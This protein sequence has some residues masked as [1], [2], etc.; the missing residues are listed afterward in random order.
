MFRSLR[1]PLSVAL[2]AS[3]SAVLRHPCYMCPYSR[4]G[5]TSKCTTQITPSKQSTPPPAAGQMA[6]LHAF[7]TPDGRQQPPVLA[8]QTPYR[9]GGTPHAQVYPSDAPFVNHHATHL[10][11][12]AANVTG[13]EGYADEENVPGVEGA[14]ALAPTPMPPLPPPVAPLPSAPPSG[15]DVQPMKAGAGKKG[16]RLRAALLWVGVLVALVLAVVTLALLRRD[17]GD[18][19]HQQSINASAVSGNAG[20]NNGLSAEQATA[21]LDRVSVLEQLLGGAA[22][23]GGGSGSDTG[24]GSVPAPP[25]FSDDT[26]DGSSSIVLYNVSR[27]T[28]ADDVAFPAPSCKDDCLWTRTYRPGDVIL[29][30]ALEAGQWRVVLRGHYSQPGKDAYAGFV[31]RTKASGSVGSETLQVHPSQYAF[32]FI[33][34]YGGSFRY[35]R[36]STTNL[37]TELNF[38]LRTAANV[39][40]VLVLPGRNDCWSVN[41]MDAE[42]IR[43]DAYAATLQVQVASLM[44]QVA[45]LQEEVQQLQPKP[46]NSCATNSTAT[47]MVAFATANP[48]VPSEAVPLYLARTGRIAHGVVHGQQGQHIF[49]HSAASS[50]FTAQLPSNVDS[51]YGLLAGDVSV[52]GYASAIVDG[53]WR[54]GSFQLSRAENSSTQVSVYCGPFETACPSGD[55]VGYSSFGTSWLRL[56]EEAACGDD[57]SPMLDYFVDSVPVVL[58]TGVQSISVSVDV[59]RVGNT[60]TAHVPAFAQRDTSFAANMGYTGTL[61]SASDVARIG[62]LRDSLSGYVA[63]R[64]GTV[65]RWTHGSWELDEEVGSSDGSIR[66]RIWCGPLGTRCTSQSEPFG[67]QA[68]QLSWQVSG[69]PLPPPMPRPLPVLSESVSVIFSMI[70]GYQFSLTIQLVRM[71][72]VVHARFP[73]LKRSLS[74]ENNQP[75]FLATLPAD[76]DAKFGLSSAVAP[77]GTPTLPPVLPNQGVGVIQATYVSLF[78]YGGWN[79][80]T[81]NVMRPTGGSTQFSVHCGT[82]ADWCPSGQTVGWQPFVLIWHAIDE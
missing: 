36:G 24:G 19:R 16:E 73:F 38:G 47:I 74:F 34:R 30:R 1:I 9:S 71:G 53:Q 44:A 68:F 77:W 49:S 65:D 25:I 63:I 67:W 33:Q 29:T 82:P 52:V 21:L 57:S 56:Q 70:G 3:K 22:L 50:Y 40:V 41:G 35:I 17:I 59:S 45:A 39:E 28:L 18:L 32:G 60:V 46:A 79:Q 27:V 12:H 80:G 6:A 48:P 54:H 14:P 11:A 31:V 69:P 7:V 4:S 75:F 15:V 8:H 23:S 72:R 62:K 76:A 37:F 5:P 58:S 51:R 64:T 81:V 66:L 61:L 42:W 55:D 43:T 78:L 10:Q 2:R 26:S 13:T 20:V